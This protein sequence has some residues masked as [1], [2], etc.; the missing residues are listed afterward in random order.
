MNTFFDLREFLIT[1]LKKIKICICLSLVC[2]IGGCLVRFIPLIIEYI[3]YEAPSVESSV[4]FQGEFPYSYQSR[5]TLYI[6]PQYKNIDGEMIDETAIIVHAYKECYQN[7]EILQPLV[8]QYFADAAIA[9]ADL[10]QKM[11]DYN[12]R[13]KSVLE[14][15]YTLPDFYN[16]ISIRT[17]GGNESSPGNYVHIYATTGDESLSEQIVNDA[18]KLISG[19]VKELIGHFNYTIT[20][21]QIGMIRPQATNG[22]IPKTLGS[23]KPANVSRIELSYI[24][25]RT[26]KGGIWGL[27]AGIGLSAL[28]CFFVNCISLTLVSEADLHN[29]SIPV[30]AAIKFSNKKHLF[31]FIDT[32]IDILEGNNQNCL[33]YE[34][35]AAIVK[36][37]LH[38][39]LEKNSGNIVITGTGQAQFRSLFSDK[40]MDIETQ[41]IVQDAGCINL[42]PSAVT[43]IGNSDGVILFE[44]IGH[45]NK[46]EIQKEIDH[47][48]Q[49]GKVIYGIVLQK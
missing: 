35:A 48:Q 22:L 25:K 7:K 5:R 29:F 18:E 45:S 20:E 47:I 41:Y 13:T 36:S 24:I 27:A 2:I 28:F 37:Y 3:T 33:S 46:Q 1:I 30:L 12:Y 31:S 39:F 43:V 38:T 14:E 4:E 40:L 34:D 32:W 15:I 23:D 6:E 11:V 16:T 17:A 19:Y 49:L 9:F 44:E 8:D 26:I 10:N 21:G 42:S